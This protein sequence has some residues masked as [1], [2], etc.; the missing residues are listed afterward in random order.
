MLLKQ[1][2]IAAFEE[3]T[4]WH[5]RPEGLCRDDVC[6]PIDSV[7]IKTLAAAL[8]MPL[9]TDDANGLWALGPPYGGKALATA[10][11]PSLVLPDLNG[12]PFDLA[13]LK[14]TKVLLLA[15]ASW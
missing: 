15:W 13:T 3:A 4:G 8:R 1:P 14:G 6:I 7:D 11:A 2:T 10:T 12:Q 5:V 9:V